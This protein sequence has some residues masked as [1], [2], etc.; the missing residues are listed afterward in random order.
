MVALTDHPDDA[1]LL[2]LF[3]AGYWSQRTRANYASILKG[4]FTWCARHGHDVLAAADPRVVERWIADVQARRYAANT[5][6][7]QVSAVSAFYRWCVR[8]QFTDRNPVEAIRRPRRPSE[9]STASLTRHQL[10][11]WLSATEQRGGAWWAAAMLLGLNGLRCGELIACDVSDI[12]SHSWHHTLA[13]GPPRASGRP[14][15][16]D[17]IPVAR[18]PRSGSHRS[19]HAGRRYRRGHPSSCWP[20]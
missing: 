15:Q 8:E 2:D 9:S 4:W 19:D 7:S 5:V 13:C 1:R 6:A 11:D 16:P 10:T 20:T 3:L 17:V 14:R 12:G 18:G